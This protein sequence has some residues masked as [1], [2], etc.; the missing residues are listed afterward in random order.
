VFS[1][2]TFS[3]ILETSKTSAKA[4]IGHVIKIGE[5]EGLVERC[6]FALKILKFWGSR[7]SFLDIIGQEFQLK[8]QEGAHAMFITYKFHISCLYFYC[9]L[10]ARSLVLAEVAGSSL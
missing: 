6:I 8:I 4:I 2:E 1:K 9:V 5:I 3:C 10:N 7:W